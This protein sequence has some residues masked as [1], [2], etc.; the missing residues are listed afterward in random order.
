MLGCKGNASV[1]QEG[2]GS[3]QNP[4]RS[5][6]WVLGNDRPCSILCDSTTPRSRGNIS[7]PA[8]TEGTEPQA[9]PGSPDL[10]LRSSVHISSC[11][12]P[13]WD[14]CWLPKW[15]Q[16]SHTRWQS[17]A[18]TDKESTVPSVIP[19]FAKPSICHPHND[20][21]SL[22]FSSHL[23]WLA[24]VSFMPMGKSGGDSHAN[25]WQSRRWSLL[26]PFTSTGRAETLPKSS[27]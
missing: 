8:A 14:E 11:S 21:H 25:A 22:V 5:T 10:K 1:L 27:V 19:R 13:R 12:A 2:P 3:I 18:G 15:R 9:D 6:G 23:R 7:F 17:P 26:P 4:H 20:V 16:A 24:H